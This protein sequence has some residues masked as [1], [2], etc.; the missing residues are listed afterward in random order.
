MKDGV[1]GTET[2]C[3]LAGTA[4]TDVGT[5]FG[6]DDQSTTTPV[7]SEIETMLLDLKL[8]TQLYGTTTGLENEVGTNKVAGTE[9]HE[10]IAT[11]TIADE[12]TGATT[13]DGTEYGK[14]VY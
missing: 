10:L 9:T 13:L 3:V 6:T 1:A 5:E 4:M 11:L 8:E 7:E 12:T 14:S 2:I